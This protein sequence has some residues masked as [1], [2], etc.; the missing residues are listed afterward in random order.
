M[1][2]FICICRASEGEEDEN[3]QKLQAS[4]V[5]C[6]RNFFEFEDYIDM[7][8]NLCLDFGKGRKL[9]IKLKTLI[10]SNGQF[11]LQN[12]SEINDH[13]FSPTEDEPRS[14][15]KM[16]SSQY[17]AGSS[18]LSVDTSNDDLPV[19][20]A[21]KKTTAESFCG[22]MPAVN[23]IVSEDSQILVGNECKSFNLSS[24]SMESGVSV[25]IDVVGTDSSH[26][27]VHEDHQSNL[28]KVEDTFSPPNH[29]RENN[30]H[31]PLSEVEGSEDATNQV[32]NDLSNHS[33]IEILSCESSQLN[34]VN[35]PTEVSSH[36]NSSPKPCCGEE[37]HQSMET[38]SVSKP[39]VPLAHSDGEFPIPAQTNSSN[40]ELREIT[41][42]PAFPSAHT[43][44]RP[45]DMSVFKLDG[46]RQA[47]SS[48]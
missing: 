19:A 11:E 46:D 24:C 5:S 48:K 34:G 21:L 18:S 37:L 25:E 47:P 6:V 35:Y 26:E 15:P 33:P 12:Q 32:P 22:E 42:L 39:L 10:Q 8:G 14:L 40:E 7:I 41:D 30:A 38:L 44:D 13:S 23:T 1:I 3:S 27:I 2:I 28:C 29:G 36:Q 43:I 9:K 4:L 45:L 31:K 17:A 16:L 20:S